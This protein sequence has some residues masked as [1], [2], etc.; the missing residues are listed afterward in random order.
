M[1]QN[2]FEKALL[3]EWV[4]FLDANPDDITSPEEYPDHALVTFDQMLAMTNNAREALTHE[5]QK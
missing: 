3:A 4:N 2:D 1:S 5:V